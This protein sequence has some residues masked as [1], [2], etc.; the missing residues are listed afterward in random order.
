MKNKQK[1]SQ[2]Q[3]Q[4]MAL[5]PITL[6]SGSPKTSLEQNRSASPSMFESRGADHDG[7]GMSEEE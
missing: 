7:F 4:R 3:S 1:Y 6:L 5:R 2:P